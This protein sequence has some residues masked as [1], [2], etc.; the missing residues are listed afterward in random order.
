VSGALL[1]LAGVGWLAFWALL[2]LP[3]LSVT[4]ASALLLAAMTTPIVGRLR[5][6]GLPAGA[7]AL[8][9]VLLLLGVLL[10]IGLLMGF[11]A[12]ATLQDLTRPL[13]AAVDRIRSWLIEGPLALD[14]QQVAETRD[15]IVSWLYRAVPSPAEGARGALY[16]VSGLLLVLFLVFF[17]HKDGARMWTWLLARVP[18]RQRDRVDGAGREAWDT[19]TRY[20]GGIVVVALIDAIA[21]GAALFGL[22]VPLWPSLTLLT[23]L[24]AFVPLF[25]ATIS[26]AVAV[27]VTM[28]TN[29]PTAA[30]VVLV[31]VVVVQQV[32]GNLLHP[33]ILGRA[34]NLHP[35]VILTAVTG[36]TLS[37][38]VSGALFTVPV[39][40]VAYRV[41]EFLRTS[42]AAGRLRAGPEPESQGLT[43]VRPGP[44]SGQPAAEPE[45]GGS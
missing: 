20:T 1:A 37:L 25:G 42:P 19:L 36:G 28:V 29:G 10:G 39:V 2:R 23:F 41:Y 6:A 3:L 8:A 45:V 27:L 12:T 17:L 24:A 38:G 43:R 22:G 13:A 15:E 4:V 44:T 9:A 16:A 33:L 7:A 21:I 14:A 40:A 34:V 30:L 26:G 35:L 5:R 31:V 32:E 18:A 11:R